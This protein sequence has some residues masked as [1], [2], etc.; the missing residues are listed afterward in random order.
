MLIAIS[1]CINDGQKHVLVNT[2]Q[3]SIEVWQDTVKLHTLQKVHVTFILVFNVTMSIALR[4][5]VTSYVTMLEPDE[6]MHLCWLAMV[7]F[8]LF[9][10]DIFQG[11]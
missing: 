2:V 1:V 4:T 11:Y 6:P 5:F 10:S 3:S 9:H 7:A 8:E